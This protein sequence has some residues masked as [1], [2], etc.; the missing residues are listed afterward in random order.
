MWEN[1][2]LYLIIKLW[3]GKMNKHEQVIF[4]KMNKS[5]HDFGPFQLL[6]LSMGF[7]MFIHLP[8]PAKEIQWFCRKRPKKKEKDHSIAVPACLFWTSSV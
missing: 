6:F 1:I 5:F 3:K 2:C 4:H 7:D 8:T